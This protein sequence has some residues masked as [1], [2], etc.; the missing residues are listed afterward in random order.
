MFK[1]ITSSDDRYTPNEGQYL[2][3][4]PPSSET[5]YPIPRISHDALNIVNIPIQTSVY[6]PVYRPFALPNPYLHN[7]ALSPKYVQTVAPIK[8]GKSHFVLHHAHFILS[9][10]LIPLFLP[11]KTIHAVYKPFKQRPYTHQSVSSPYSKY[12]VTVNSPIVAHPKLNYYHDDYLTAQ[13]G[14]RN[15][16][17]LF[18]YLSVH[19]ISFAI[20]SRFKSVKR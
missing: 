4:M 19:F 11:I 14:K 3:Y 5:T 9:H 12:K 15:L 20:T 10:A 7:P 8:N 6:Q 18:S 1:V 2:Y 17:L 13:V 16:F